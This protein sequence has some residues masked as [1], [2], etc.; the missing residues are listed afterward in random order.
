[1]FAQRK[2]WTASIQADYD[3]FFPINV[4]KKPDHAVQ[5]AVDPHKDAP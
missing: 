2:R 4:A 1:M 3:C 5:R